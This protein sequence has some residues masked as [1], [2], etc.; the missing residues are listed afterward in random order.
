ML[1]AA[2]NM[3]ARGR[4][5]RG[6]RNGRA[7]AARN[8]SN[9][10]KNKSNQDI[11][12]K[13]FHPQMKGKLPEH[14][15]DEVK[16][17]LVTALEL[18][19][20]EK[21]DDIIDSI[22][23]MVMLDLDA[24]RPQQQQSVAATR[25]EREA[26]NETFRDE[27]KYEIKKWDSRVDALA[28]NKRKV[29]AKTIRFCTEE[30]KAKLERET[31]YETILFRNPIELLKRIRKFMTTSEETDW[32]FFTLWEAMGRL[33]NCRQYP[34]EA[35]NDFRKRFEERAKVF[36][37]L[38]G[39]DFLDHFA[40]GSAGYS[41]LTGTDVAGVESQEQVEFKAQ[42]WEMLQANGMMYNCDRSRYQ[43]R[44][45]TMNSAYM[46]VH[47][48][49]AQRMIYP[50]TL[51]NATETL[52]RH[53]VDN[54]KSKFVRNV[55]QNWNGG[56]TG[57]A[58]SRAGNSSHGSHGSSNNSGT[59]LAQTSTYNGERAC[60]VCGNKQHIAPT[61]PHKNRPR[62]QWVK[63][64]KYRDYSNLQ[65]GG[66]GSQSGQTRH[67]SMMQ[68]GSNNDNTDNER[69]VRM[70][71]GSTFG[72]SFMQLGRANSFPFKTTTETILA[73]SGIFGDD[74]DSS[75]IQVAKTSNPSDDQER[76]LLHGVHMDSGS[77]FGMA[78]K[79]DECKEGTI[80]DLAKP[81]NY[82]SNVGSRDILKEGVSKMYGKIKK[83]IDPE[84]MASVDSLSQMVDNG[85]DV[86]FDSRKENGFI[87]HYKGVIRR[88]PMKYG[89]YTHMEGDTV[90][91]DL[92]DEIGRDLLFKQFQRVQA[93][94]GIMTKMEGCEAT[95]YVL[96]RE[97]KIYKMI[98]RDLEAGNP[99]A[100][101]EEMENRA[102][103]GM[104]QKAQEEFL[105][106]YKVDETNIHNILTK[107]Y[108]GIPTNYVGGITDVFSHSQLDG[109]TIA[110]I[111]RENPYMAQLPAAKRAKQQLPMPD[112]FDVID[113]WETE[114][115][116]LKADKAKADHHN[117][118]YNDQLNNEE[119][120]GYCGMQSVLKNKEGFTEKQVS[121][122]N[123]AR[124]GYFAAGAPSEQAFKLAVRSG[125]FK[126][127]T[128]EEEDIKIAE[129]IYGPSVAVFKGKKKRPT[130][131][132]VV[133]D[134]IE[135]PEELIMNNADLDLCVD[136]MFVNNMVALTGVDKQVK[137]RH[138]IELDRRTKKSLYSG[139]D[140]VFRVYNHA[141]FTIRAIYCDREFRHI[142]EDIKDELGIHMNYTSA[143]EH[144]PTAER[145][146]QHLKNLI[147]T[148]FHRTPYKAIPKLMTAAF[149]RNAARTSNFYPAKGGIS[150]Y[151]S[152]QMI[153]LKRKVDF[154][155]E[156]AVE[157]GAY[158]Q[159][160]GHETR[161]NQKTR[162]VDA[163]YLEPANNSQGGHILMD[164]ATGKEIQR[165]HVKVLPITSQVIKMVEDMAANEGVKGVRTYTRRTGAVILDADLLA[166]V[167][168]DELWN[169]D[170]EIEDETYDPNE[171]IPP[172]GDSNLR[173]ERIDDDEVNDLI[174]DAADDFQI[175]DGPDDLYEEEVVNRIVNRIKQKKENDKRKENDDSDDEDFELVQHPEED[176]PIDENKTQEEM[177]D[178]LA[179]ELKEL[180]EE[181]E[182]SNEIVFESDSDDDTDDD[183]PEL[184]IRRRSRFKLGD[185]TDSSSDS[186]SDSDSDDDDDDEDD[187]SFKEDDKVVEEKKKLRSGRAFWQNGKKMRPSDRNGRERLRF[188]AYHNVKK[189]K[190][191]SKNN[192]SAMRRKERIRRLKKRLRFE[193]S[194][195]QRSRRQWSPSK[196]KL[197][198][199]F[200]ERKQ[201]LVLQQVDSSHKKMYA[202]DEAHLV[203]NLI[204]QIREKVMAPD[205]FSFIQQYY[206]TKGLKKFGNEGKNA[207]MKEMKQLWERN[208]WTPK[209]IS[210]LTAMERQKAV[211]GMMLL[212]EKNDGEKKGRYVFK[213]SET[214]E[215]LSREETS[216]PTA[217]QE[218]IACTCV[219]D[220][221]ED[222]DV[223]S[224]DIPNAF[225]QTLMPEVKEGE[226]RVTM[227]ITGL[228]V[229]YMIEIDP[230]Y[231]DYI[232]MEN[233]K[234]VIYVVILRAIYGMLEASLLFYKKI[235][236]DLEKVGF[237]FNPYD[238]CVANKMVRGK[239]HTVRFHVDDLMASHV[240]PIVN[241]QFLSWLNKKYGSLKPVTSTRGNIHTYLG[242][243]LDFSRKN[244]VK[245]RMDEY[246]TRMLEEF[247]VKFKPTDAQ[248]TP[249]AANLLEPGKGAKLDPKRKE[250]FHSFVA[251][252]LFLSKRAR[253]D[254]APTVAILA[255]RVREP[256]QGDWGRLVR[257]MRYLH[258]TR[259]WHLSL[260]ADNLRV[261]KWYVDA[262]FATHPDYKSHTGAVMT[263]G[264]G[265]M[266]I[267][268][269]K[270]KLNSRS[271][272]EAELIGV[273]DAITQVLWTKLFMEKQGYPIKDNVLY[274]DNK[275]SILLET[276]GRSSAGKRSRALNIRYFFVTDQVK[277][278]NV[279][280]EYMP[281]D[282]MW[283]DFM[284]KPLQGEKF[285]KF[286]ALIQGEQD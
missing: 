269:R 201:N 207:A 2:R 109:A 248:E 174:D 247:P 125:L 76:R 214:R 254:I 262:A 100:W 65:T 204:G 236:G 161:R 233:G 82:G 55:T 152:P 251:K 223:M 116:N 273:D 177:M 110:Q 159:G 34:N 164:L 276:N 51:H 136:L 45:D 212:A 130:P 145:N 282:E 135:I 225:I 284:T 238:P 272:T 57:N 168:P 123:R 91:E 28:N 54:G 14:S 199:R 137:F 232:V 134:W 163:I 60:Y 216:S 21:S 271:S 24:I 185:H 157:P 39:A 29:H 92:Y 37:S 261:I 75:Y 108:K 26:E 181:D 84:A 105:G 219:I 226:E 173:I 106:G 62:E 186:D 176:L 83:K 22:R 182:K 59:N 72:I 13:Q 68:V 151:Y 203:A 18:S 66:T 228:L 132:A 73:Q 58:G 33:V 246:V 133:N 239:Q 243:T 202:R 171:D 121:R 193:T 87:V 196:K 56:R 275:S 113:E 187:R 250:I 198:K 128:V 10:P 16:K 146:N 277:Q 118:L 192:R 230:S 6:G 210:E 190:P 265:A 61:C 274:Q 178:E 131:D 227:K 257:L 167:D 63:P 90:G 99:S 9:A 213:G 124:S 154:A 79:E 268:T 64:D 244:K 166:G 44:I 67:R 122:A 17:E 278:G 285:R 147:R 12:K 7:N 194:L 211:E 96:D 237:V 140:E 127:C 266:Q 19:D 229:D 141:G 40:Q 234:R 183:L 162:T 114:V 71:T 27:W 270:Q 149:G 279:S 241:D 139:I 256:T 11:K 119:S 81:F 95:K 215:W 253:L 98:K 102:R 283:A 224:A 260:S 218:A 89:L 267:M 103:F 46:V 104:N 209:L 180:E 153:V 25:A 101:V 222:R 41:V 36:S 148:Q 85:Y 264:G 188:S 231:R 74:D 15:F 200:L 107:L 20:M 286:R 259:G 150:K 42:A 155:K 158:V 112:V 1:S 144:E 189:K 3:N 208:C 235:R 78:T 115:G 206:I 35:P 191:N 165:K 258:S 179:M 47:Q 255:S 195:L 175:Q 111:R 280:I 8:A 69:R 43:S 129:K 143:G 30:M 245:I 221:K 172:I 138:C 170:N 70:D 160:W 50:T 242:M 97:E 52:N 77:T 117:S 31:D 169:E 53:R 80:I 142:F 184:V 49:Y 120:T 156:C 94:E 249:A 263:M 23:N 252:C 86:I 240:N 126:N 4:G 281:T 88:Y 197:M 38:L 48:P 217:S 5:G 220:A 93:L 205:N 32:D